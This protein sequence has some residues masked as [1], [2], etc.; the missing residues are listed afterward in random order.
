MYWH[1]QSIDFV[2]AFPQDP[3][4]SYIYMIPYKVPKV[5]KIPD[6]KHPSNVFT[7]LYILLK[8]LYGFNNSGRSWYDLLKYILVNRGWKQ[9]TIDTCLFSKS[10]II[11]IVYVDYYILL[12]PSKANIQYKINPLQESFYLTDDI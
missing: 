5:F 8:N 9:S 1:I 6:L 11:L 12:L 7:E 3:M 10:G 2:L 4:N